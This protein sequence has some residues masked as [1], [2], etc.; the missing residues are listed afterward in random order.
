M[1]NGATA[2]T[3]GST[4]HYLRGHTK[5]V[6]S[7]VFSPDGSRLASTG[8]DGT[9][10]L[11]SPAT[12]EMLIS[13]SLPEQGGSVAFSPDGERL[14]VGT[15]DGHVRIYDLAGRE[16]QS[17]EGQGRITGVRFS[18]AGDR[19]AWCGYSGCGIVSVRS[20]TKPRSFRDQG[21][22]FALA[23]SPD[24]QTLATVGPGDSMTLR[25]V[26]SLEVKQQLTHGARPGCWN[27]A[28]TPDGATLVLA[29]G[30][31]VQFWDVAKGELRQLLQDHQEI[32]SGLAISADAQRLAT[33]SWD[34]TILL[35]GLEGGV[36]RRLAS[37]DWQIGRLHDVALSP[38]G[39]IAAAAGEGDSSLVVWDLE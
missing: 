31:G 7:T 11:W 16:Q 30:D 29:L 6:E 27:V 8:A 10:R 39:M 14:A 38:D 24:S 18:P 15:Y 17:W 4:M 9:L 19:L 21:M 3:K 5:F 20:K 23:F 12:G 28:F 32:V 37:Y 35:Y 25:K 22:V 34:K 33:C 26:S 36:P 1:Y 2:N 13:C